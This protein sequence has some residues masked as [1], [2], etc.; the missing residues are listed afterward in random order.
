VGREVREDMAA[1]KAAGLLVEMHGSRKNPTY[2]FLQPMVREAA[3]LGLEKKDRQRIHRTIARRLI[4]GSKKG[5]AI[6]DVRVAWH[7]ERSG[8]T[9]AAGA[10][11]V[12]AANAAAARYSDREA[13]KLYDRAIPL[14]R[15]NSRE[16]FLALAQREQVLRYLGRFDERE[17]ETAEMKR[18]AVLLYDDV[19][20]AEA[21]MR[22]AQLKYDLG[23]YDRAARIL[24][25]SLEI[26][27]RS[28]DETMQVE[29]LRL[30]AFVAIQWGHLFRA[31]DCANRALAA[32]R[33]TNEHSFYLKA[34]ALDVKGFAL[35]QMG[36][37]NDA[38]APL[39]EGLVL[40][41]RLRQHR[42][43]SQATLHMALLARARGGMAEALEF[44]ER[45]QRIDRKIRATRPRGL[46]LA[47]MAA[48]RAD[49][50][51]F[52]GAR[53]NLADAE[54]ICRENQE[55]VGLAEVDLITAQLN[56][57]EGQYGLA[58]EILESLGR[59]AVV[60]Q[61]RI[62]LVWH[63]QLT[64]KAL[65][66]EGRAAAAQKLADEAA[67]IALEARCRGSCWRKPVW[68]GRRPAPPLGPP[69][70]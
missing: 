40:F 9:E 65:L 34:L 37:L 10:R 50:G 70:C 1:L 24:T 42:S 32:V 4:D 53:A 59:R 23:D 60:S 68:N 14:I 8:E 62:L 26:A 45:A 21:L 30:L 3:Y 46:K 13:L 48:I 29:S 61:S 18:I 49:A 43:E 11:Y 20:I 69:T 55:R 6:P 56:I 63:R 51:D 33:S 7:L 66:G 41:R 64:V 39:A 19:L 27:K 12:K 38:A 5:E 25:E 57:I 58:L 31:V 35:M 2:R 52:D 17:R 44:L 22:Q 28:E 67:R 16:K 36:H 47:A 15:S 54:R